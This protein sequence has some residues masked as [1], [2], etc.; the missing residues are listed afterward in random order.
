MNNESNDI[1]ITER[2][3]RDFENDWIVGVV[4]NIC[5][6]K[7]FEVQN[8][9]DILC[10]NVYDEDYDMMWA[11]DQD[12]AKR[13]L[14]FSSKQSQ[15]CSEPPLNRIWVYRLRKSLTTRGF[16]NESSRIDDVL[17]LFLFEFKIF[18]SDKNIVDISHDNHS[19]INKFK[20][21]NI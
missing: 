4:D 11:R 17:S 19:F 5:V 6:F 1:L 9:K 12:I 14:I 20:Y 10:K 16:R 3:K 21:H 2:N 8:S 13:L 18:N 15:T 7:L